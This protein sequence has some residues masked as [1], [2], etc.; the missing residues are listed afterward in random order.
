MKSDDFCQSWRDSRSNAERNAF[1]NGP[2]FRLLNSQVNAKLGLQGSNQLSGADIRIIWD[3]CRYEKKLDLTIPSAWCA[4]FSIAN[5]QTL[6]YATDLQY[7]YGT[8]YGNPNRR[9]TENNSCGLMQDLLRYLQSSNANDQRARIFG[10]HASGIQLMMV[11][12]GAFEDEDHLT[13]HNIAQTMARQWRNSW[14][15]PMAGNLAAVRYE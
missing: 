13:R 2:E 15:S 4:P 8:G 9:L 6:E 12:L 14:I 1:Y 10:T 5:S 3:I 11:A 7:Y